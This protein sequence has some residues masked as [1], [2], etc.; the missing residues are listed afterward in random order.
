MSFVA[1]RT[2]STSSSATAQVTTIELVTGSGP[3]WNSTGAAVGRPSEACSA[4]AAA[5]A[6]WAPC[7]AAKPASENQAHVVRAKN[8]L[9]KR[10]R[11]QAK[12]GQLRDA[13]TPREQSF[14]EMR[15]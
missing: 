10:M 6:A 3:T 4:W 14:S 13:K 2:A 11:S 8:V 9:I 1:T 15:P 12:N 5:S 7:S